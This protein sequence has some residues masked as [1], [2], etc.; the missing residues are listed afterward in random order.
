[1]ERREF[2]RRAVVGL[3]AVAIGG[4]LS[5]AAPA[6]PKVEHRHEVPPMSYVRFGR[7]NLAVSRLVHG[8]LHTTRERL[9]LLAA[10]Y[11]GGVNFFDTAWRYGG[12]RSE[13]AFGEFFGQAGRRDKV[14]LA[15]K[16]DIRDQLKAGRGAYEEA[17]KQTETSLKRLR[18]DRLDM[19]MLHGCTTLIDWID[20]PEW[21]RACDDLKRQGKVRFIG[22]SEHAKPAEV[23]QKMAASGRYDMAMI[24]FSVTR[25]EWGGLS[26]TDRKSIEPAL[27]VARKA[28][29]GIVVMKAAMQADQIV[30]EAPDPRLK[31]SGY[32]AWQLC[33]RWVLDVPNVH[34]VVSGMTNM[35]HVEEN[36][37]VPGMSLAS[38]DRRALERLAARS[39]VCGF[40]GT[41]LDACERGVAVQD[42]LRFHG[43]WRHGYREAARADYAALAAGERADACRDCGA[44]ESAC[45]RRLPIRRLLREAHDALA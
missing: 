4:R 20:H 29:L 27:E 2:I 9:P 6:D 32:S 3:G 7:T 31:K 1:M 19:L 26:R 13:E 35:T 21:L 5:A 17:V 39:S 41:C 37:K 30:G 24:A 40:C 43:Y 28:D 36:L 11:D 34:A 14:F 45:P 12:G 33:Y 16:V 18:T 23:L 15:S 8:S 44:C 25:G 38:A 42:I 22:V 10:L